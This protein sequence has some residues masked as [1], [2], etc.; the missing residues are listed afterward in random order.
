M[1]SSILYESGGNVGVSTTAPGYKSGEI[2]V[3]SRIC[4]DSGDYLWLQGDNSRGIAF[5]TDGPNERMHIDPSGNV[6]I[7]TTAPVCKLDVNGDIY[8][9]GT[10]QPSDEQLKTEVQPLAGVLDK[11]DRIRAVSFR[12]NE[13]ART[14]GAKTSTRQIGVLAQELEQVFP[15]LVR[16]PEPITVEELLKGR[17]EKTLTAEVRQRLQEDV[18]KARYKA[19]NYRELTVVLLEAR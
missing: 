1:T 12:W 19:V 2:R 8:C 13:K 14:L 4:G 10:Y 9:S 6:G 15:E 11:L 17:S 16:T 5:Q 7:G 3:S 18:E